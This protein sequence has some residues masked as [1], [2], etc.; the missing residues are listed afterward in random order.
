[1]SH[2]TTCHGHIRATYVLRMER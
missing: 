2:N 1:M